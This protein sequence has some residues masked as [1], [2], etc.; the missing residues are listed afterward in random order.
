MPHTKCKAQLHDQPNS[1]FS[2]SLHQKKKCKMQ[3]AKCATK[4]DTHR[5]TLYEICPRFT[6]EHPKYELET[7][8]TV[9]TTAP[10]PSC[11]SAK[12]ISSPPLA[13]AVPQRCPRP[14]PRPRRHTLSPPASSL[15]R[16]ASSAP[17]PPPQNPTRFSTSF[18]CAATKFATYRRWSWLSP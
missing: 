15:P 12:S 13:S 6:S 7:T 8:H 10:S 5:N 11:P 2:H 18:V 14:R 16:R 3:N 1:N 4:R 9:H 17:H